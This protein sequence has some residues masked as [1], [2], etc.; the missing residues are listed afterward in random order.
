MHMTCDR[1]VVVK[2]S[3]IKVSGTDYGIWVSREHQH[4]IKELHGKR[5]IALVI[6]LD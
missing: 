2:G 1:I 6:P 3:V 4:K 5:V